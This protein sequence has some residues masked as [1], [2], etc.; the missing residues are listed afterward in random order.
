MTQLKKNSEFE[1]PEIK[2]AVDASN[3]PADGNEVTSKVLAQRKDI[4]ELHNRLATMLATLNKTLENGTT[5]K[6]Q[7]DRAELVAKLDKVEDAV[8]KMEGTLRI[9]LEP[10]LREMVEEAISQN[11]AP[12]TRPTIRAL[13][14]IVFFVSG[15]ALGSAYSVQIRNASFATVAKISD[16]WAIAQAKLPLNGGSQAQE[17]QTE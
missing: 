7:K 3:Q 8:N 17:N 4:V 14:I 12:R 10:M 15:L 2:A 13:A 11:P 5:Q 1:G 16:N 6:A 9:E